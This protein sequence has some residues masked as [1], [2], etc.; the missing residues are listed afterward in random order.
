MKKVENVEKGNAW[1]ID[2]SNIIRGKIVFFIFA[3]NTI[4]EKVVIHVISLQ[5]DT[6]T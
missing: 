1:L 6:D 3:K 4:H 5:G 2:L